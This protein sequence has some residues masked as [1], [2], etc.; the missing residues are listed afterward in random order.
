MVKLIKRL[1]DLPSGFTAG[2]ATIG[3]FDGVHR[4]HAQIIRRLMTLARENDGPGVVFTFV[5][6]PVRLLRPE[7]APPALVWIER[8]AELLGELGV[9]VVVA[10]PT[11]RVLLDLSAEQFFKQIII[12]RLRARAVIEGPNF[13]F[14]KDRQG[15]V[16]NLQSL[17]L[18]AEI[19]CEIVEPILATSEFISSSRIR[20]CIAAG[21][22][23]QANQML[24][25]P[26]RIRGT[27]S[28]GAG[29][30]ST[31]GF[32]TANLEQVDT[33]L[34]KTGVY[35]AIARLDGQIW[36]AAVN[37]GPNPT[38]A[39]QEFKVEAH[40]I[41]FNQNI[42]GRTLEI[43]FHQRLR[44]ILPFASIDKL[45]EQLQADVAKTLQLLEVTS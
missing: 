36:P 26:Y 21:Q 29:R 25:Q 18:N 28:A 30:G 5:P 20:S 27:V 44:D 40:L 19:V 7:F 33:L 39:E 38:F 3:N 22:I 37:V 10:Y 4:G 42:Y 1:E 23:A 34:P 32:A 15:D 6:H 24:I 17:C 2:A 16:T 14:G 8:K 35:A 11:D 31:L 41:R 43:E 13:Y 45:V 12:D 9:D